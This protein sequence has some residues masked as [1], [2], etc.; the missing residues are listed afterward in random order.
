[1]SEV[2]IH[3]AHFLLYRIDLLCVTLEHMNTQHFS[4]QIPTVV[5]S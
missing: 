2:L 1:M 4:I 5:L 3:Y